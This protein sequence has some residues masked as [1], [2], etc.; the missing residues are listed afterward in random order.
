MVKVV[1]GEKTIRLWL[2]NPVAPV[3]HIS[4]SL[5]HLF[6]NLCVVA[7]YQCSISNEM[8]IVDIEALLYSKVHAVLEC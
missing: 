5:Y 7:V 6:R 1:K 3:L 2:R 4:I 8:V